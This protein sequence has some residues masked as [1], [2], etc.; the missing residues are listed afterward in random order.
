MN[1][2]H[3]G[4]ILQLATNAIYTTMIRGRTVPEV[5]VTERAISSCVKISMSVNNQGYVAQASATTP[6]ATTPVSALL[7]TCK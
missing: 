1:G 2:R 5:D 6:S 7:T 4:I 3:L